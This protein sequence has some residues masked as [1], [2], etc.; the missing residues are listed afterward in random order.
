[1]DAVEFIHDDTTGEPVELEAVVRG[2]TGA[3]AVVVFLRSRRSG[4]LTSL[5]EYIAAGLEVRGFATV[6]INLLSALEQADDDRTGRR[7][8][9]REF[10]RT[11]AAAVLQ[12][13]GAH[14]E[15]QLLPLGLFADGAAVATALLAAA[16]APDRLRALVCLDGRVDLAEPDYRAI[17]TD[18]LLL[19]A[20][21]NTHV[22]D[23]NRHAQMHIRGARLELVPDATHEYDEA[24]ALSHVAWRTVEWFSQVLTHGTDTNRTR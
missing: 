11:R 18:T 23:L 6:Q 1:M 24:G 15:L 5:N 19:V 10:H 12:W 9:D 3:R 14:A 2:L 16:A 7:H 22:A 13:I 17:R 21:A 8:L 4:W 20:D